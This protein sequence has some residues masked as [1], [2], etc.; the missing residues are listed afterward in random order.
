MDEAQIRKNLSDEEYR[1]MREKGTELPFSGE[2][3]YCSSDGVY[4]CKLCGSPLF[5]SSS[6]FESGCGWPSFSEPHEYNNIEE[7]LDLSHGMVRTEVICKNCKS[8]LGHVFN[9]G[10]AP[11][12]RRYCINSCCLKLKKS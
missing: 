3:V 5:D 7:K 4:H 10:P 11:S 8:H 12:Y 1:V 6:K 2:Y 9:D